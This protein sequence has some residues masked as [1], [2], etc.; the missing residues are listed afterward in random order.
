MLILNGN[1]TCHS[2][3]KYQIRQELLLT[4]K[5][6]ILY[7]KSTIINFNKEVNFNPID[8][9]PTKKQLDQCFTGYQIVSRLTITLETP[10]TILQLQQMKDE[11]TLQ[12][13]DSNSILLQLSLAKD[14][15]QIKLYNGKDSVLGIRMCARLLRNQNTLYMTNILKCRS[16]I[17]SE[18]RLTFYV[19]YK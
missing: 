2:L 11:M 1:H 8:K 14:L 13:G 3:T 4:L 6:N 9:F 15:L 18:N 19:T 5:S 12:A 17:N 7:S 10:Y 16:H